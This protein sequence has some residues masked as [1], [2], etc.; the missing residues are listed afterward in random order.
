[1]S[2][3]TRYR[4]WHIVVRGVY[5]ISS[6]IHFLDTLPCSYVLSPL[7]DRDEDITG[8]LC[9]PH[10]H[11]LLLFDSPTTKEHVE[12]LFINTLCSKPVGIFSLR[13]SIR[14]LCHLDSPNRPLYDVS[15]VLSRG[16]HAQFYLK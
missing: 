14:Y 6:L 1:M 9:S 4:N 11:V 3:P 5:L 16:I 13:D 10:Y 2:Q 8:H 7:H 15:Q 12:A